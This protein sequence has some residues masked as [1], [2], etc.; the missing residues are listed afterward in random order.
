[1]ATNV[2]ARNIL[3]GLFNKW[4]GKSEEKVEDVQTTI[5][6]QP[7][8]LYNLRF[9][10]GTK[11]SGGRRLDAYFGNVYL[12]PCWKEEKEESKPD[13]RNRYVQPDAQQRN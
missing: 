13:A 6:A 11:C 12:C 9:K 2:E 4:N 7:T 1:M 5:M 8:K 3:Q 10:V